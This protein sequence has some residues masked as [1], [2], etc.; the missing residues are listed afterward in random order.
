MKT[1]HAEIL[2]ALRAFGHMIREEIK[3]EVEEQIGESLSNL[4]VAEALEDLLGRSEIYRLADGRYG[5][6]S[7]R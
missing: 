1:L 5:I 7:A 2:A 3:R 4:T 6:P